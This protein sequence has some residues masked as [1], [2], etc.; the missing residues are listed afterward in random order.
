MS[1]QST[2]NESF[3]IPK[4]YNK[5]AI[6]DLI[7]GKTEVIAIG[8][9]HATA[10]KPINVAASL[11]IAPLCGCIETD[12]VIPLQSYQLYNDGLTLFFKISDRRIPLNQQRELRRITSPLDLVGGSTLS[13]AISFDDA[14]RIACRYTFLNEWHKVS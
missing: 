14:D 11:T 5:Q 3:F 8:L 6:K 2:E 9:E 1:T 12:I 10:H 4:T 13:L 7:S